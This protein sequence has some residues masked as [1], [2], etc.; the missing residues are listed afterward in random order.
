METRVVGRLVKDAKTGV[1]KKGQ[2]VI[3][4]S[5]A[6]NEQY[7]T[8]TGEIKKVT[9]YIDCSWWTKAAVT[10]HLQKGTLVELT[11]RINA[12]AWL[13]GE[14]QPKVALT[15]TVHRLLLHGSSKTKSSENQSSEMTADGLPF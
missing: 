4:F 13:T 2:P 12:R 11:G 8:N 3:Y 14:G 6:V 5:V 10:P 1:S 7:K 9:S 15:L